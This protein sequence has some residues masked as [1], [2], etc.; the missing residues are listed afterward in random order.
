MISAEIDCAPKPSRPKR[1]AAA[2]T[3]AKRHGAVTFQ[4]GDPGIGRGGDHAA[5][6]VGQDAAALML[7]EPCGGGQFR[8]RP[9]AA[10]RHRLPG[11]RELDHDRRHAAEMH[12]FALQ[13]AQSDA[14]RHAGVD[15]VAAGFQ[16]FE[17][18]LRGEIIGRRHHV[19]RA[20]DA[21]MVGGHA[22]LVGHCGLLLEPSP[23]GGNFA[24]TVPEPGARVKP[25]RRRHCAGV[26]S[27]ASTW[28]SARGVWWMPASSPRY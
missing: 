3:S 24:C 13:H 27:A 22:M 14:R 23:V 10:D 2:A 20:E 25:W 9:E 21:R 26:M 19:P 16:D 11:F 17:P 4:R 18:G 15:R 12:V 8:P 28:P 7:A 5:L 1:I 6:D